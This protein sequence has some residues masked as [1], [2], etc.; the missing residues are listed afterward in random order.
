MPDGLLSIIQ[1]LFEAAVAG[2]VGGGIRAF[3]ENG[4]IRAYIS[5]C[6]IGLVFTSFIGYGLRYLEF[7][8][9]EKGTGFNFPGLLLLFTAGYFTKEVARLLA[10]KGKAIFPSLLSPKTN[11]S[12]NSDK[13]A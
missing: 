2:I 3:S 13:D 6:F 1:F 7:V 11:D 12:T 8:V 10:E 5:R 4:E 9:N